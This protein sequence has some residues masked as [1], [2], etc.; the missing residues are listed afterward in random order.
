MTS[1]AIVGVLWVC[2]V[3]ATGCNCIKWITRQIELSQLPRKTDYTRLPVIDSTKPNFDG[4]P[5]IELFPAQLAE[6][7]ECGQDLLIRRIEGVLPSSIVCK[8]CNT[9]YGKEFIDNAKV[10]FW[11]DC[12]SCGEEIIA[13]LEYVAEEDVFLIPSEVECPLCNQVF[14]LPDSA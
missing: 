12:S 7:P 14:A 13:M 11:F 4:E 6:C 5:D 8:G 1:K 10:V 2:Y 9:E 3:V